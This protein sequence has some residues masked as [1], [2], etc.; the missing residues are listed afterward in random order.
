MAYAYSNSEMC[1]MHFLY[2][3]ANGN[4]L[5]ARYPRRQIPHHSTFARLHQRLGET[6][7]LSKNVLNSGAPAKVS[8][9]EE[10]AVLN[11]I[12]E[13]P[14]TSTR[15]I[16]FALNLTQSTVWRLLKKHLLHP[17]HIQRVQALLPTDFLPRENFCR[18]FLNEVRANPQFLP[19]I[20]F[21]DEANFSRDA[22]M[23]FHNN[24]YWVGRR[25]PT[26]V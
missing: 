13:C 8:L 12:E 23:N 6:G 14:T 21:T 25:E 9:R 17:Y 18:W 11:Y 15:K 3:L 7:T 24:H 26:H 22:I 16:A 1:D 5:E 19:Q 10:E 20:C 2:G 4:S